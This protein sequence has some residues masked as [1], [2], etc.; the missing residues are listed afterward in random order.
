MNKSSRF[1]FSSLCFGFAFLYVPILVLVVYSFNQSAITS[2]WGGFSLRWY[3]ALFDNE[4]IIDA[5]LLSLRIAAVSATFATIL[6][7]MAGL[8]LAQMGRYRGTIY[9]AYRCPSC[10]ARGH[11]WII[12]TAHVRKFTRTGRVAN[13][14]R[15][16]HNYDCS[17]YILYGLCG[18]YCAIPTE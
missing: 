11:H 18:S 13:V 17:H 2:V 10:N 5:A 16:K 7:T 9:R 4:Q 6:G 15:S 14:Q 12:F 8:A 1:V 3:F